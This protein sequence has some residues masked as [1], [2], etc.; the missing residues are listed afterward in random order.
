MVARVGADHTLACLELVACFE[1]FDAL[2]SHA[3]AEAFLGSAKSHEV[4]GEE[5]KHLTLMASQSSHV[6]GLKA[7]VA[8]EFSALELLSTQLTLDHDLGA[9]ALNVLE[10]LRASHMLILLLVTDVAAKLGALNHGVLLELEQRLP[11]DLALLAV[12]VASMRELTEVDAVAQDFVDLD[13]EVAALLAVRAAN[14]ITGSQ[15][16]VGLRVLRSIGGLASRTITRRRI[17]IDELAIL[18]VSAGQL[19]LAVLAEQLVA[20]SALLGR[21]GELLA[22]D[23][24]D[25]LDHL[26]LQLVLNLIDLDVELRN[27]VGAHDLLNCLVRDDEVSSVDV[28]LGTG[29][30]SLL[31]HLLSHGVNNKCGLVLLCRPSL[32]GNGLDEILLGVAHNLAAVMLVGGLSWLSVLHHVSL[33]NLLTLARS[34]ELLLLRSR[35]RLLLQRHAPIIIYLRGLALHL[36]PVSTG[37]RWVTVQIASGAA[38]VTRSRSV[39]TWLLV[40]QLL[41]LASETTLA[42]FIGV[43]LLTSLSRRVLLSTGTLKEHFVRNKLLLVHKAWIFTRLHS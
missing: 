38:D 11:D 39:A 32:L 18:P 3:Q 40:V 33:I 10:E 16:D 21:V 25:L 26:T 41:L 29:K 43:H 7:F 27:G 2:R 24:R 9:F 34:I 37:G 19:E 8:R 5:F 35:N 23:A 28:V 14:V 22:H 17:R 30:A 13:D 42:D 15:T 6:L 20:L 1:S 4:L 36:R 12:N 31:I